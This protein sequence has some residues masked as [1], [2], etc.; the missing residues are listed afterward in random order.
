[1]STCNYFEQD[2][3]RDTDLCNLQNQVRRI[4]QRIDKLSTSLKISHC[5]TIS[6]GE[7]VFCIEFKEVLTIKRIIMLGIEFRN[8]MEECT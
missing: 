6:D 3:V 4:P 7:S 8:L 1:M 2:T 5:Q